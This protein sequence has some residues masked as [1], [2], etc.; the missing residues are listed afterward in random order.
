MSFRDISVTLTE[1]LDKQTKQAQGI[2]FT[3]KEARDHIFR[4]LKR[5]RVKPTSVLEPSFGSGEFLEDL[6]QTYPSA[7]ITG[8]ELNPTL[9]AASSR[10]NLVNLDFLKY[11]GQ[12]DLIV[13]NPPYVVIPASSETQKCQSGRPNLFVQFLYKAVRDNLVDGGILAFVLPTSLFNCVYY[14]L[15]RTYLYETTTLLAVDPLEGAYL[16]TQQATF[17]LVLRKKKGRHTFFLERA[18]NHY[19]T[20]HYRT[21]RALLKGSTTL[22]ALGFR[23]KT[24]DVVWNQVKDKLA[25][26]GT[27]LIYSS[28]FSTGKVI[29]NTLALPKKQYVQGIDKPPLSGQSILINR[30]YG[31]TTY[32]LT[33]VMVDYP[34]YYAENHVNVI[35]P[36]TEDARKHIAAVYASLQSPRTN[37]FIRQFVGNGAL[38]KTELEQCLPIWL[39]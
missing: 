16:E 1:T 6:Y 33:A 22:H 30:G 35:L 9:F 26:E 25:D 11:E 2:F 31:N 24:G 34:T 37:E 19:I 13:G 15:L 4:I 18:G 12:H 39:D 28:N 21:L 5:F 32:A 14:E 10:P 20:P 8:V 7:T 27:L 36:E 23:V 17:A 29:L 3:P 38:S